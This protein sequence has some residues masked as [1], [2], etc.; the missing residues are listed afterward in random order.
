M[1]VGFPRHAELIS[2][3]A[4]VPLAGIVNGLET[5]LK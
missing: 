5:N 2:A 4:L 3:S 1:T